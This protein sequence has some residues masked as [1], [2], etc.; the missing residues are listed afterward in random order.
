VQAAGLIS[1]RRMAEFEVVVYEPML[2]EERFFNSEVV[3]DLPAFKAR[4]D[5]I[6]TNRRTADLA[7]VDEKVYTR[8]L[9]GGD[10]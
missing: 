9:F 5:L 3:H 8:D 4:C 1:K 7:D 10:V 6:V 2:A